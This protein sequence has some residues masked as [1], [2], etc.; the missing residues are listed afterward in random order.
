M[1]HVNNL[2]RLAAYTTAKTQQQPTIDDMQATYTVSRDDLAQLIDFQI[3]T[4]PTAKTQRFKVLLI[5][6]VATLAL[7]LLVLSQSEKPLLRAAVDIWPLLIAPVFFAAFFLP[8]LRWKMRR[9]ATRFLDEGQ[10][11]GLYGECQLDVGVDSLTETRPSGVTVRNWDSIERVV[12]TPDHL[13]VFTSGLEA[14]VVPRRDIPSAPDFDAL[15]ADIAKR[16]GVAV[17][18]SN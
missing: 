11:I 3:R 8:Y 18:S 2:C 12:S 10:N 4:S 7:P 13:F 9:T 16:A 1:I 14:F 6:T 5:G 15:A 17:E